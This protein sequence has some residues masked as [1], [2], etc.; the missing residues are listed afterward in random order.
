MKMI[1]AV[2]KW[3]TEGRLQRPKI[4]VSYHTVFCIPL[5]VADEHKRVHGVYDVHSSPK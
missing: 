3:A 4:L 1:A 2:G 5:I